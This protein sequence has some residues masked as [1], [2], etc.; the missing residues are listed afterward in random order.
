M[1]HANSPHTLSCFNWLKLYL[2][3]K[4]LKW[5]HYW[6][7]S[8]LSTMPLMSLS[9]MRSWA[10]EHSSHVCE[11]VFRA[12]ASPSILGEGG[13]PQFQLPTGCEGH[14]CDSTNYRGRKPEILTFTARVARLNRDPSN[15]FTLPLL[16]SVI[17]KWGVLLRECCF[18]ATAALEKNEND[19]VPLNGKKWKKQWWSFSNCKHM[20]DPKHIWIWTLSKSND[21][22]DLSSMRPMSL[23]VKIHVY[24]LK[25]IV[26]L[27]KH[28]NKR[29]CFV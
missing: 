21:A 19:P 1:H 20:K 10:H 5:P 26:D 14:R 7:I 12:S 17:P 22:V 8:N 29:K 11:C 4:S 24:A 9:C 25:L 18:N 6:T 13:S 23:T 15:Y 2:I 28:S 27:S 16:P 3:T